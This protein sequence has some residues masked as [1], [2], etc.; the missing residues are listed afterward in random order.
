MIFHVTTADTD[1]LITVL[2]CISQIPLYIILCV[3]VGLYSKNALRYINV[4]KLYG[5][6]GDPVCKFLPAYHALT[7][8]DYTASFSRKGKVRPL[9][10][11]KRMKLCNK[12]LVA[13]VSMRK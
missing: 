11:S 5:K 4:N 3:E 9:N 2:G 7:G 12:Y 8:C 10:T 1:V 13:W 6:I